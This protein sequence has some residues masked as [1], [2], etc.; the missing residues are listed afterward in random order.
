MTKKQPPVLSPVASFMDD[1]EK[2]LALAQSIVG[3]SAIAEELVQD[4]WLRWSSKNYAP[5][6]ARPILRRIVANLCL[7]WLRKHRT[8]QAG[9]KF[10]GLFL[11]LS[12]DAERIVISR[13]EL[14]RVIDVLGELPERTVVAFYM[15]R[16]DGQTLQEIS[17][18]LD[19]S[20]TR[21]H[22]LIREALVHLT[23]RL[24]D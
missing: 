23:L 6:L 9:L 17:D 14:E 18:H 10:F 15:N 20:I 8:E 24:G 5:E 19:I 3:N 21:S 22:Q 11:D 12:P 7:D 2:L 4:S 1:R 16:V 13:Q